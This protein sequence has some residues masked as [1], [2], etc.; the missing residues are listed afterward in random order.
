MITYSV[1]TKNKKTLKVF[2]ALNSYLF[3][4]SEMK[5]KGVKET[6]IK[7]LKAA[8]KVLSKIVAAGTQKRKG[9]EWDSDKVSLCIG[10]SFF[11][12]FKWEDEPLEV[13]LTPVVKS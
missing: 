9:E 11:P 2:N 1:K 4:Q 13:M 6:D 3:E 12:E 8:C 5:L 7:K 10:D